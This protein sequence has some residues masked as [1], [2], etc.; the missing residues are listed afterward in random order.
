VPGVRD[1]TQTAVLVPGVRDIT[2]TA[3]LV[4][5][6]SRQ[7][8][9]LPSHGSTGA[10]PLTAVLVPALSRQYWCLP[11]HGST[12]ACPLTA[13][14]VP[15]LSR[16]YWCP[17]SHGSTGACPPRVSPRPLLSRLRRSRVFRTRIWRWHFLTSKNAAIDESSTKTLAR[18]SIQQHARALANCCPWYQS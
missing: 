9:C 8:W 1:H 3:V 15:A 11:S 10:C 12:G 14:L 5:A 4:P 7:Y 6:L 17:P 2:H 18:R 16:Q 13:V